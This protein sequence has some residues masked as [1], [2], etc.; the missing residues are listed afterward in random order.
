MSSQNNSSHSILLIYEELQP[1]FFMSLITHA[2]VEN[3][4]NGDKIWQTLSMASN[5]ISF[6]IM[7]NKEEAKC[8]QT[9]YQN[10]RVLSNIHFLFVCDDLTNI[11]FWLQDLRYS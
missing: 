8:V 11:K 5:N 1:I 6:Q 9:V 3:N 4:N 10:N 7:I 2:D